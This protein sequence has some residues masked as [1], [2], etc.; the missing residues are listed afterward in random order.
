MA[1]APQKPPQLLME[2]PDVGGL[3]PVAV[4]APYAV[5]AYR[6]GDEAAWAE[7]MNHGLGEG[8]TAERCVE[9]LTGRPQFDP[10]S[11][12]FVT[13]EG[14]PVGSACAWSTPEH[15]PTIGWLHM[16]C[17]RPEHRGRRL[18]Y[19]VSLRAL[20]RMRERGFATARLLTDDVRLAAI[21][22]YLAL[23]FRPLHTHESH[24]GRWDAILA[25][26]AARHSE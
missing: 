9:T 6:P 3:P 26:L 2:R 1:A 4:P 18:G 21:R 11:L 8:W 24:P 5:R 22:E 13:L 12:F 10:A 20:H 17:V 23:G 19:C 14:E 25:T 16:V 7:I 15:D